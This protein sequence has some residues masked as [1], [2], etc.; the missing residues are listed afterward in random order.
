MEYS[1]LIKKIL[2]IYILLILFGSSVAAQQSHFAKSVDGTNIH[3]LTIGNGDPVLIINGGPGFSSEG[4]VPMAKEIASLGYQT[5]LY[6]Q[7]GTGKSQMTTRDTS[8]ITMDLMNAD[9]EA[10]REDLGYEDWVVLGHS[11]GG[12]M[13]NYY[14]AKH[15]RHVKGIIHS[16][17]GG[18]D[19]A[20]LQNAQRHLY[21]RLTAQEADSLNYYRQQFASTGNQAYRRKYVSYLAHAY[22]YHKEHVP[23][24][25]ERLMQGDLALNALV[26]RN[27]QSIGY[28]CKDEL[29]GFNKPVFIIQGEQDIVPKELAEIAHNV[30]ANSTVVMLPESGHYG[31][32]DQKDR[33]YG[34]IRSFLSK[35]YTK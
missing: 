30:F 21:A 3:Y 14:T 6:D 4:F 23:V 2:S 31:W 19:L 22:V 8:N 11:F 18:I 10:I 20:L 5:I 35:I 24:I 26:W 32:L 28:D 25:V 16:S 34:S 1:K 7:R 15:T 29:S 17:S 12:I 27:L 33:Y 13:A 9:I